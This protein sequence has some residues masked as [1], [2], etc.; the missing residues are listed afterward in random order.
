MV[1]RI[2]LHEGF[3][4]WGGG[5]ST[6]PNKFSII[7][8]IGTPEKVPPILGNSKCHA[9]L[10]TIEKK[11]TVPIR[12]TIRV[13]NMN[14]NSLSAACGADSQFPLLRFLFTFISLVLA[15]QVAS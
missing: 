3:Q 7:L 8:L 12:R 4:K 10:S 9:K 11:V 2:G 5:A 13:M 14:S 15:G 6:D 1:E